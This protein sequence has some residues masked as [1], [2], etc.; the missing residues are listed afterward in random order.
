M[1]NL[2]NT[3]DTGSEGIITVFFLI[4]YFILPLRLIVQEGYRDNGSVSGLL[5]SWTS[6]GGLTVFLKSILLSSLFRYAEL[7]ECSTHMGIQ[8]L[9]MIGA[10]LVTMSFIINKIFNIFLQ[11]REETGN[12]S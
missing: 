5:T 4:G 1:D 6:L 11:D 7:K 8:P 12:Q 10:V 2:F 9:L 3:L